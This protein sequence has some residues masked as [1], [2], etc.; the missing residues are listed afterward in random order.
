MRRIFIRGNLCEGEM[1]PVLEKLEK[2]FKAQSQCR[3]DPTVRQTGRRK[4]LKLPCASKWL[5]PSQSA[6]LKPK[7]SAGEDLP[8]LTETDLHWSGIPLVL[9]HWLGIVPGCECNADSE[10]QLLGLSASYAHTQEGWPARFRGCHRYFVQVPSLC[11]AVP[12]TSC[13]PPAGVLSG[14]VEGESRQFHSF[15]R[16]LIVPSKMEAQRGLPL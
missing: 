9:S 12:V 11:S 7:L 15:Q 5:W 10:R 16:L 2:T 14:T 6:V 1:E 13:H 3:S 8:C 4:T